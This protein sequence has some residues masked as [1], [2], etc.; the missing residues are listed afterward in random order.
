MCEMASGRPMFP[1]K[2]SA[3]QLWLTMQTLGPLPARQAGLMAE[4]STY[5]GVKVSVGITN[6]V[7]VPKCRHFALEPVSF[8]HH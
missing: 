1:G 6:T 5:D 4:D 8:L 2:T 3:D 7:L